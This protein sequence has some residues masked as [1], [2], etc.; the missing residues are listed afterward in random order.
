M[1]TLKDAIYGFAVGDAIGVPYEFKERGTFKAK[2]MV[3][4]GTHDQPAGTWSDDTATV[5]AT[6]AS[7]KDCKGIN[8]QDMT[9]RFRKWLYDG[10]YTIDGTF[11]VGNTTKKALEQNKGCN[12]EQDSGNGSLM[13]ILPL[14][15]TNAS[16]EQIQA[17]SAITHA[18][19]ISTKACVVYVRYAQALIAKARPV[20]SLKAM[21]IKDKEFSRL[22][23]IKR[24]VRSDI[25]SSGYALDTL[26]AAIWCVVTTSSYSACVLRAINLGGDTDTIGALAGALAGITYGYCGIPAE[27]ID[28]LRGKDIIENSL[29]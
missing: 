22:K 10:A 25:K 11:D 9:E 18:N 8:T 2:G 5:L 23:S 28:I 24:L 3:G 26:E 13:R 1:T 15:F 20:E 14:A 12:G 16:T 7:I 21:G 17:V 27:W 4:Y 19:E 29:F 6:C